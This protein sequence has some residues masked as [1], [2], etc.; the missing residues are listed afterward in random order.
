MQER[1]VDPDSFNPDGETRGQELEP[2]FIPNAPYIGSFAL[3]VLRSA[4]YESVIVR[5]A[6]AGRNDH[7][8]AVPLA[9]FFE[10]RYKV[11]MDEDLIARTSAKKFFDAEVSHA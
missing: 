11:G 7:R 5:A 6:I 10:R 1:P 2:V 3:W 8:L 9:D 4:A